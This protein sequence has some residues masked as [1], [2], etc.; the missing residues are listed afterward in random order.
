MSP[1]SKIIVKELFKRYEIPCNSNTVAE[2]LEGNQY[3]IKSILR[4]IGVHT[5]YLKFHITLYAKF[6][7]LNEYDTPHVRLYS[8]FLGYFQ[9]LQ[10]VIT[11]VRSELERHERF[12]VALTSRTLLHIFKIVVVIL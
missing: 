4:H 11:E 3:Y 5:G 10:P 12:Y 9:N 2:C 7:M 1:N 6:N 8:E